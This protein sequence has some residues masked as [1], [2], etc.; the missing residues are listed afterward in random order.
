MRFERRLED[1]QIQTLVDP[2]KLLTTDD[3][4]GVGRGVATGR[5][6]I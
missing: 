5:M 4:F 1:F 2:G 6:I 3:A